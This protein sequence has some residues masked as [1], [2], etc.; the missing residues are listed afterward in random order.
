MIKNGIEVIKRNGITY[1]Y[2]NGRKIRYK[3]WLGDLFSFLYDSIMT[4]SVFPKKFEAS[5]EKHKQFLKD[6]LSGTHDKSVLEL[7]TGSGNISEILPCNNIY[8][9]IDISEG[10][11]RI[12][13]KKFL[14]A[15]FKYFELFVCGAEELPFQDQLFDICI[16]NLSLNFFSD[17]ASVIQ[18]VKRVLKYKGIFICSVPVPEKNQKQSVIRGNLYSENELKNIFETNGFNFTSYDFR[19]GALL[20]FKAV[21]RD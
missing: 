18:E 15:E 4:K 21:K 6:E 19:N 12:A 8:T 14:K 11:L 17:L 13:Y 16:C 3:P 5:I 9:G 20:Y 1:L 2:K 10:L 7:A